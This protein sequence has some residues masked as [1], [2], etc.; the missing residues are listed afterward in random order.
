MKDL[1]SKMT[2]NQRIGVIVG[3]VLVLVIIGALAGNPKKK[4]ATKTETKVEKPIE[5]EIPVEPAVVPAEDSE[6]EASST[7]IAAGDEVGS[8]MEE[9]STYCFECAD[10]LEYGDITSV[11]DEYQPKYENLLST[12]NVCIGQIE[13][14]NTS[15]SVWLDCKTTMLQSCDYYKQGIEKAIAS[16]EVI[17]SGDI[18]AGVALVQ[19]GTTLIEQG[20]AIL[21]AATERFQ[22]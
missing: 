7:L 10:A 16:M 18:D 6:T 21:E 20:N 14:V 13:G 3:L 19:E 5:K 1:W 12:L 22:L 15:D 11:V 8:I 17:G 9:F 2:R 4:E